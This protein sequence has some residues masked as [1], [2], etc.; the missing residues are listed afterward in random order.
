MTEHYKEE[1]DWRDLIRKPE[2]LFGFSYIYVL[3]VLLGIGL[4]YLRHMNTIGRNTLTPVLLKDSTALLQDIPLHSPQVIPPIDIMK[5]GTSSPEMVSKGRE[6]FKANCASCHGDNGKGD[7]PSAVTME[8]KPRNFHSLSAWKNGSKI[9]QMYKTLQ[10]GIPGGGMAAFNYMLPEDR[11]AL[12]HFIRTLASKQP[13]DSPDDLKQ[14]DATYQLAKGLNIAGQI[15]IKKAMRIV[16]Q[17]QKPLIAKV[18]ELIE[19]TG[20]SHT[21]GAE[22]LKR[23]SVDEQKIFTSALQIQSSVKNVGDFIRIVSADPTHLGY[24][25]NVVRLSSDEWTTLYRYLFSNTK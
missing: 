7:G 3:V 14:L 10:E 21:E 8:P 19:T 17:E 16:V 13:Q 5:A 22:L 2:K 24:K 20:T 18:V 1:M 15:P 4:L 9:S 6:L 11:F 25:A 12:I 23:V